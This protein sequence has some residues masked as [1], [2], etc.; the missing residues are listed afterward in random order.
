MPPS[1]PDIQIEQVFD[2]ANTNEDKSDDSILL[3]CPMSNANLIE[4][5]DVSV[6]NVFI[7]AAFADKPT[8]LLYTDLTSTF[9][10]ISLNGKVCFLIVYHYKSNTILALPIANFTNETIL[11][12]YKHQFEL[13]ESRG[14]KILLNI[15]DNQASRV[16]KR[17][18]TINQCE[19]LL[20][21]PT[22]HGVNVAEHAI[23]PLKA[24]FISALATTDSKFSLQLWNQLTPQV[25]A[26]LNMLRPL[27]IDPTMSA[28]EAI[29]GSYNWNQFPLAP[30]RCK[31]VIYEA[32]ELRGLWVSHGTDAWCVC[33]CPG[34][35]LRGFKL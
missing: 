31:A 12:V 25:E 9:P 29:Y 1:N 23:Q 32:P 30:P 10:F 26:T 27:R 35:R 7:L 15:M 33:V 34:F 24:H 8:G 5:D 16:I 22:N 21:E 11:T 2:T 28:Y 17:N 4:S 18:L 6:A 19:N 13:L 20:V 14:H 3:D